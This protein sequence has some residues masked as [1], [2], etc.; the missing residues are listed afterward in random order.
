[1]HT[2]PVWQPSKDYI[3]DAIAAVVDAE[4]LSLDDHR[5]EGNLQLLLGLTAAGATHDEQYA[6]DRATVALDSGV[7]GSVQ[8]QRLWRYMRQVRDIRNNARLAESKKEALLRRVI[9][10]TFSG[11]PAEAWDMRA[12]IV[13]YGRGVMMEAVDRREHYQNLLRCTISVI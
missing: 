1:V 11:Q 2:A 6:A 5:T 8:Q 13:A 3:D 4:L 12:A 9:A 10:G 7:L